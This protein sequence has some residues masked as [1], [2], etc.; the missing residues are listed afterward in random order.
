MSIPVEALQLRCEQ[1]GKPKDLGSLA[2][3]EMQQNAKT[4]LLRQKDVRAQCS[5]VKDEEQE[6]RRKQDGVSS[7]N[8]RP[9]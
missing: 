7:H 6:Q 9:P 4:T 8:I 5:E 1:F 3:S 2:G